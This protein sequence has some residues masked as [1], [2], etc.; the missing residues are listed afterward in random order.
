[1]DFPRL[2]YPIKTKVLSP[3][4]ELIVLAYDMCYRAMDKIDPASDDADYNHD[5]IANLSNLG[6]YIE[7]TIAKGIAEAIFDVESYQREGIFQGDEP[8]SMA[9][10]IL[11]KNMDLAIQSEEEKLK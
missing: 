3:E 4:H 7:H 11:L 8:M 10:E 2:K 5:L 1:M 6:Y 9:D